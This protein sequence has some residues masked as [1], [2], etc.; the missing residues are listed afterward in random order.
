MNDN[1][2]QAF[3]IFICRCSI[4]VFFRL[5]RSQR[6]RQ[7]LNHMKGVH[8]FGKSHP[9][10]IT[11]FMNLFMC[12]FFSRHSKL[13]LLLS[14]YFGHW[15]CW[16]SLRCLPTFTYMNVS[17]FVHTTYSSGDALLISL[18]VLVVYLLIITSGSVVCQQLCKLYDHKFCQHCESFH[19]HC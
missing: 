4:F 14:E 7:Q 9:G 1:S 19:L 18:H 5:C 17:I 12:R 2:K 3:H 13:F 8:K 6:Q 16:P 10:T 11:N 15:Y